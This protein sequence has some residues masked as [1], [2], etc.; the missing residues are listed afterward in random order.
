MDTAKTTDADG[1]EI[2]NKFT[3]H[4]EE[5]EIKSEMEVDTPNQN[6]A[7]RSTFLEAA[8]KPKLNSFNML[9]DLT[10]AHDDVTKSSNS[11]G[12][13]QTN[14]EQRLKRCNVINWVK[15]SVVFGTAW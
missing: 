15:A 13:L 8:I 9:R 11:T 1:N 10:E 5:S 3:P 6:N 2:L 14:S 4:K 7:T 12:G